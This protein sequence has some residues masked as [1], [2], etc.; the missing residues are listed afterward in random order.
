[1]AVYLAYVRLDDFSVRMMGEIWEN[2][3]L[4]TAIPPVT[5]D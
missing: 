5:R 3:F 4:F 1:M 2:V